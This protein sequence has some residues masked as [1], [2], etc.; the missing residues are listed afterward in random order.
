[1]NFIQKLQAQN[2]ARSEAITAARDGIAEL[3]S[4]LTSP[5]FHTDTTVQVN[6]VLLRLREIEAAITEKEDAIPE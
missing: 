1:M 2:T 3:R 4:Y 6:D 5:K